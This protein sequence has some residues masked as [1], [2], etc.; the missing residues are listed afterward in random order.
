MALFVDAGNI[1]LLPT[2]ANESIPLSTFQFG[3][4][5]S[6]LSE[7]AI[8]T[9]VGF[10]FDFDYFVFRVDFGQPVR[11]PSLAPAKRLLTLN[12]YTTRRTVLN[13]GIGYPF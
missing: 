11:D 4:Q 5:N 2:R 1:W 6:A 7:I 10:R 12:Q 3:G 8:G 13:I 9:G